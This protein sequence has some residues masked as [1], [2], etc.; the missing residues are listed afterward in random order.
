[1][2]D[3]LKKENTILST[4]IKNFIE[5]I[6]K[7]ANKVFKKKKNETQFF[8]A[9]D[10][11]LMIDNPNSFINENDVEMSENNTHD[12]IIEKK[13]KKKKEKEK[14]DLIKIQSGECICLFYMI[15]FFFYDYIR[16]NINKIE[17]KNLI[18]HKKMCDLLNKFELT[19]DKKKL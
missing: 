18:C 2:I 6:H 8:R 9:E 16:E 1:M 5:K 4:N 13:K 19:G 7:L 3:F 17:V 11:I 14:L 12:I 10:D 15:F